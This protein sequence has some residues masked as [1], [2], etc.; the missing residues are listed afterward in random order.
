MAG[1]TPAEAVQNFLG[2]LQQ[3][4]SCVTKTVLNVS[5]GYSPREDGEPHT[6]VLGDGSPDRLGSNPPLFLTVALHYH[7]VE[8][9]GKR[10]PWKVSIA[11]YWYS[12]DDEQGQEILAFHWHPR[13]RSSVT[14]P[15][16]HIGPGA[17]VQYPRLR[18]A[19]IPTGRVALEDVLRLAIR[20]LGVEPLRRDWADVLDRTQRAFEQWRTWPAPDHPLGP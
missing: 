1:R 15:H 19:H 12:L 9:S 11:A 4:I 8:A 14:S 13:G 2:P 10:G 18:G 17:G 20:E 7:I 3:A 6:L 5:G 16:L